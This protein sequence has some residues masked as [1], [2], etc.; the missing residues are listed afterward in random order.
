M[1]KLYGIDNNTS[2]N[3]IKLKEAIEAMAWE[4]LSTSTPV[5]T[6]Y[7][8]M[9]G[10]C[11]VE[12]KKYRFKL[13]AFLYQVVIYNNSMEIYNK[14]R[15]RTYLLNFFN[16][17]GYGKHIYYN[18]SFFMLLYL[19]QQKQKGDKFKHE[20]DFNGNKFIMYFRVK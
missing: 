7:S 10:A 9:G 6:L 18:K 8:L 5:D 4:K 14:S 13:T 12:G 1:T 19:F 2:E 20:M 11:Y 17:P 16:V 3:G 15:N